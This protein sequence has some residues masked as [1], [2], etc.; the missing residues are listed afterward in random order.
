MSAQLTEAERETFRLDDLYIRNHRRHK[1]C[2]ADTV[3]D[4][5]TY[6]QANCFNAH[7][8][9]LFTTMLEDLH[10]K[11]AVG[12]WRMKLF[13]LAFVDIVHAKS[14]MHLDDGARGRLYDLVVHGHVGRFHGYVNKKKVCLVD[15]I[16]RRLLFDCFCL[17][18]TGTQA[19][20]VPPH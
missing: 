14:D 20:P 1:S 5:A 9:F 4:I 8:W 6:V 10:G 19:H 3:L 18:T 11:T 12:I 16:F 13:T 7:V 15:D 2:N 17:V